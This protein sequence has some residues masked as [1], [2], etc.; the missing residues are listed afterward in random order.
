VK[1]LLA[2][3]RDK[4]GQALGNNF[5]GEKIRSM[6]SAFLRCGHGDRTRISFAVNELTQDSDLDYGETGTIHSF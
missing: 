3:V 1:L 4:P 2:V 5:S 6:K